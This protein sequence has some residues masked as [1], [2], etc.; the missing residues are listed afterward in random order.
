MKH[1]SWLFV[2][3]LLAL[4]L[5]LS[6]CQTTGETSET[7]S[8]PAEDVSSGDE[9]SSGDT[10]SGDTDNVGGNT[11]ANWSK[12]DL[13]TSWKGSDTFLRC[14]GG[15][16]DMEG[17]GATFAS[18]K[19]SITKSGTYILS[20]NLEGQIYIKVDEAEK[21][22]LVF[23][24]F[25]LSCADYSPLYCEE[26][27]KLSIT[28]ADG[29][30]NSVTDN[31]SGY[32]QGT[33][34]G[35][36]RFAGA[37]HVKSSL[38]VNGS[39]SLAVTSSY[40]HGIVSNKNL[41]IVSGKVTVKAVEDGVKGKNSLSM[42]DG[43]L[44]VT[45]GGDGLKVTEEKKEDRGY[46]TVEGGDITV[47]AGGDGLD[48]PR[49]IQ[50]T[51]GTVRVTSIDHALRCKDAVKIGGNAVLGLSADSGKKDSD[52]KGIKADGDVEISGGT[53]RVLRSFE[54]IESKNGSVRITGG[55]IEID[56][57][58]DG[59][60]AETLI[61]IS[62]GYLF[63][64]ASGDG[65]DSNS[66]IVF[67]GGTTVVQGPTSNGDGPLDCGDREGSVIRTTG[68]VLI[69][70]GSA[71]EAKYPD[72]ASSTQYAMG[73]IVM[74]RKGIVYS[75]RDADGNA[76]CTFKALQD[77]QSLCISTPDMKNG[78]TYTL[79]EDAQPTGNATNGY[80]ADPSSTGGD[81]VL[82]FTVSSMV[83]TD[84]E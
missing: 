66:D 83:S 23:N 76:V 68:G 17:G 30:E 37:I 73:Y 39:G 55:H 80:Y 15:S 54:G 26:A 7:T 79:Y 46:L 21:V 47:E 82:S 2:C 67:S 75:L 53:L 14:S 48:V 63:I 40:R 59:I 4:S 69:A 61:E 3:F 5:V 13:D 6:G 32:V 77:A 57:S 70:Y 58:D 38:T 1:W 49:L 44:N 60:N 50:I 27:D 10:S 74:L 84:K 24:G 78:G 19:L 25:S 64:R 65:L 11:P 18:G 31:G 62:G 45:A 16:V 34:S 22:H 72:G 81:E 71:G 9:T 51:G 12:F 28:L 41:R 8:D 56:A 35:N 42:L 33:D 52:A 43:T 29:T 36:G 20:G